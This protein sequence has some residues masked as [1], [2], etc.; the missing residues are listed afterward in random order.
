MPPPLS[1]RIP[2]SAPMHHYRGSTLV[3]CVMRQTASSLS[4]TFG[5]IRLLEEGIVRSFWSIRGCQP[6]HALP[7]LVIAGSP[8]RCSPSSSIWLD[9]RHADKSLGSV[10]MATKSVSLA[11]VSGG[12]RG[13]PCRCVC[14]RGV[15]A[16]APF[17]PLPLPTPSPVPVHYFPCISCAF[18]ICQPCRLGCCFTMRTTLYLRLIHGVWIEPGL[19][20]ASTTAVKN[21]MMYIT[22]WHS[23]DA[24]WFFSVFSGLAC[25]LFTYMTTFRLLYSLNFVPD[26]SVW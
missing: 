21:S 16:A 26:T 4:T 2:P 18:Y 5:G 1:I 12:G 7:L 19:R 14:W 6:G 22:F 13:M 9:M 25:W 23:N 15:V 17:P 10:V 24:C 8:L 20:A 11:S 3:Q